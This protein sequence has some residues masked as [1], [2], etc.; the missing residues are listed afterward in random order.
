MSDDLPEPAT[1]ETAVS[2][3]L[4]MVTDTS[5]RLLS[6]ACLILSSPLAFAHLVLDRLVLFHV[7][8]GQR[9][10][11]QEPREIALV[12]HFAALAAGQGTHVHHVVG[13]G[14]HVRLVLDDQHRVALVAQLLH[15]PGHPPHIVRMQ[16]HRGL[17][18]YIGDVGQRRAEM[19]HHL[20]PLALPARQA[21]ALAVK[22]EIAQPD[23]DQVFEARSQ[24]RQHRPCLRRLDRAHQ[25]GQV[26]HLHGRQFGD[27]PAGNPARQRLSLEPRALAG[28]AD[29]AGEDAVVFGPDMR[30]QRLWV[31]AAQ[32][33]LELGHHAQIGEVDLVHLDLAPVI[34]IEQVGAFSAEYLRIGLSRSNMPERA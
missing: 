9:A 32:H 1:P 2:T 18:E 33:L 14:D 4:G 15:Q 12:D 6:R 5:L 20:D 30:L 19:A 23:G 10:G 3:P 31:L 21:R 29:L 11:G 25:R 34:Q 24:G 26:A 28:R 7:V 22:A 8:A 13:D 17:V 16:P 27:I